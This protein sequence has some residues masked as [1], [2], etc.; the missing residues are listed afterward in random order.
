MIVERPF[1]GENHAPLI[2]DFKTA[3]PNLASPF[4]LA[5]ARNG[6]LWFNTSSPHLGVMSSIG[7]FESRNLPIKTSPAG[8]ERADSFTLGPDGHLWF[9]DYYGGMIGTIGKGGHPKQFAIFGDGG[10]SAGLV[11]GPNGHLWV[12]MTG[13]YST[14][15]EVDT[16]PKI[17]NQYRLNG[18]YQEAIALGPNNTLWIGGSNSYQVVTR[19]TPDGQITDFPVSAADGVWGIAAGPD[20]N[21][22]FTGAGSPSTQC[23]I[24][25]ITPDGQITEYRIK[26]Q[27]DGVVAGPD[28]NVWFSEPWVGEVGKVT[29]QGVVTEYKIPKAVKNSSPRYQVDGIVQGPDGNLWFAEPMRSK[30]GEIVLSP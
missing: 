21:I 4:S 8:P 15:T 7:M 27:A 10:Y 5:F 9:T 2:R 11:S 6:W 14:L 19:F 23:Y 13:G 26:S 12:M 18:S 22:W 29:M 30:I 28:G 17:V 25:K 20:G 16:T 3:D 1:A 24:S